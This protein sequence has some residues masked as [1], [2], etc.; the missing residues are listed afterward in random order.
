M[1]KRRVLIIGLDG[2]TWCLGQRLLDNGVM[3]CLAK[4]V[5]EGCHGNLQ[6]VIPYE[7]AP[8]WVSFQT[9]CNPGKTGV[10]AFHTFD[11]NLKKIRLNSFADV[12][13]P[14]IWQL[15]SQAG[16]KIVSINM[17]VTC[18]PPEVN[19]II[20]PG[21]LA[22]NLSAETC[23]PAEAYDHY[24]KANKSYAIM[25]KERR[26][27]TAEIVE[28]NTRI[29]MARAEAAIQMMRDVDW[30]IF[31]L[32]MQSIDALQHL[33]WSTMRLSE[34]FD[35][36]DSASPFSFYR[37]CDNLVRQVIRA[38][39]EDVLTVIVSDHGF[40]DGLQ[41]V[42]LNV[43]LRQKGYLHLIGPRPHTLWDTI[44]DIITPLKAAA[45][46]YGSLKAHR[47]K[48]R[49]TPSAQPGI[50]ADLYCQNQLIHLRRTVDIDKTAAFCLGG[51][52]G[53]V[54]ITANG[55]DRINLRRRL[56]AELLNEFGPQSSCPAIERV[57]VAEQLYGSISVQHRT[58]D[59][60]ASYLPGHE[61]R[62][63]P[64]GPDVLITKDADGTHS[65]RGIFVAHG[66]GI[67]PGAAPFANITDVCPTILAYMGIAVPRHM[68]G[69]VL[70]EA[71]AEPLDITYGDVQHQASR[72]NEYSDI[73]QRRVEQSL[74]DLGYI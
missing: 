47:G 22:P 25:I 50:Q 57:D 71:F 46:A 40:C 34:T 14:S 2:F 74:S 18:P 38:A 61:S 60:V 9:G 39:G 56:T 13:V 7:T 17:P 53:L 24:I 44:K 43:W 33:L 49:R 6:S 52:A 27:T 72:P 23:Y 21:L 65:P 63:N 19:G 31:S 66:N 73:E 29:E 20:I 68:D 69:R 28:E 26:S 15:A 58:P 36:N 48:K 45:R 67:R 32:Q 55:E 12:A 35:P 41:S 54:Y 70:H 59:L 42:G 8:A 4:L 5:A 16:R 10:F 1:A 11:R 62:I 37:S 51:M 30:D 3:P 64:V